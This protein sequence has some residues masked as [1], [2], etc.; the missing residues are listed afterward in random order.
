MHDGLHILY[1]SECRCV[2]DFH[3]SAAFIVWGYYVIQR[4]LSLFVIASRE[5]DD[6]ST[7][8]LPMHT[9]EIKRP[10]EIQSLG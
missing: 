1:V 7:H 9:W 6:S 4:A 2:S 5:T 8:P 3:G 10:L